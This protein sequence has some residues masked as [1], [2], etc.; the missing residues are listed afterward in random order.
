MDELTPR[1]VYRR[2]T[3]T[4][5]NSRV[6]KQ[7]GGSRTSNGTSGAPSSGRP[8]C[9]EHLAERDRRLAAL[10]LPAFLLPAAAGLAVRVRIVPGARAAQPD[11][12][13]QG[14]RV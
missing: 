13:F 7:E 4:A 5:R 1:Q 2:G 11:Q 14:F 12:R 3:L 9:R 8:R 6:R 10:P